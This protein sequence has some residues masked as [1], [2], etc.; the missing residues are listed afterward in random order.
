MMKKKVLFLID[1]LDCGGA[2]KSLIALLG[3]L[4]YSR[5][6]VF[7][8][9][10]RRGG[11]LEAQLPKEVHRLPFPKP[12]VVT[13]ILTKTLFCFTRRWLSLLRIKR[14]GAEIGWVCRGRFFPRIKESF[15]VAVAYQQGFPTYFLAQ[16]VMSRKKIAWI[17]TDLGKAGYR[18]RF[19][20]PFY[21]RMSTI[22][23]VSNALGNLYSHSRFLDSKRLV[24]IKDIIDAGL[25]R[26]LA[27]EPLASPI[28]SSRP[29]LLTVGRLV[30][31]KNY[32][33]AI[34]TA[35]CLQKRGVDFIWIIVGDGSERRR[36]DAL[37]E[38]ADLQDR[39]SLAGQQ[40]NPYPFFRCCDIYVQT[41]S[42]EGF[43]LTISEAKVFHK[44]IVSTN[45]PSAYDQITDGK[46][47]L[48]AEMSPESLADKIQCIL[49]NPDMKD[50]LID[51]TRQE[52]NRTVETVSALVNRLL[53]DN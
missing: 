39:V 14:H 2:E 36:I 33:L 41:S 30:A 53:E 37:I 24:V 35:E 17:N 29:V 7:L 13:D 16:K 8:S 25:I 18:D 42:F 10:V 19:N 20:R 21:D 32:P 52:E 49:E 26:N 34:Q 50:R 23:T 9:V 45:F 6:D 28:S 31:P 51:G 11:L 22:C 43:G 44:P 15:D 38:Q 4:D 3:H 12:S 46:S 40:V 1:S 5:L 47:G 27:L 48:I